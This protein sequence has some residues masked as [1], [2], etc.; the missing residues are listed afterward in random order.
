MFLVPSRPFKKGPLVPR[1]FYSSSCNKIKIVHLYFVEDF[2]LFVA[3]L[4]WLVRNSKR[5]M[6]SCEN[7]FCGGVPY[8]VVCSLDIHINILFIYVHGMTVCHIL[9]TTEEVKIKPHPSEPHVL[10]IER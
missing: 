7:K 3:Y 2:F 10:K 5:S 4:D 6:A 9:G 8:V 1:Y